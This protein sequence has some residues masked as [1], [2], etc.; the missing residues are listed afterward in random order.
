L[1]DTLASLPSATPEG[2]RM[3]SRRHREPSQRTATGTVV[4]CI[5]V[6]AVSVPTA[7]HELA[8]T[9]DTALR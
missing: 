2:S 8:D 6:K 9:Q 7:T 1:H 3:A 5:P 4:P